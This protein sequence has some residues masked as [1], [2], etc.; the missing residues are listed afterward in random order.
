MVE[1]IEKMGMGRRTVCDVL[2]RK[3]FG[4]PSQGRRVAEEGLAK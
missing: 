3:K 4:Q 2:K 1:E